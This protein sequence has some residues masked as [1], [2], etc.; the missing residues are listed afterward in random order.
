MPQ[1]Y[2]LHPDPH[3]SSVAACP[4]TGKGLSFVLPTCIHQQLLLPQYSS[5]TVH[6]ESLLLSSSRTGRRLLG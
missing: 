3:S 6:W 2:L 5:A 1:L 4:D